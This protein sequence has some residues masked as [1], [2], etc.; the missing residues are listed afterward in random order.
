MSVDLKAR[1][2][3]TY[4][5]RN[6]LARPINKINHTHIVSYYILH[7]KNNSDTLSNAYVDIKENIIQIIRQEK[8]IR[9]VVHRTLFSTR[10]IYT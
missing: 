3:D 2:T 10:E 8:K 9:K 1:G 5:G 4:N 6:F 7:F